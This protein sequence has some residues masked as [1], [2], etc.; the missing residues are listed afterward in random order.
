MT[1]PIFVKEE[2]VLFLK[3]EKTIVVG[4]LHIGLESKMAIEGVHFPNSSLRMAEKINKIC[5]ECHANSIIFLGDIKERIGFST[6][7]ETEMLR[8]F[9]RA[10]EGKKI[11]VAKGNHDA[12][13]KQLLESLN[14]DIK[15]ENEFLIGDFAIMHG[16]SWP[17][18]EA[19][20]K[21]YIVIGHMH[22]AIKAQGRFE[23]IW[24]IS[25]AAKK[26]KERYEKYFKGI[27]L[28]LAPAFTDLIVGSGINARTKSKL[29]LFKG[30]VFEFEN[31]SVYDL[32]GNLLGR[33]KQLYSD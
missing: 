6:Q 12:H 26:A 7:V 33:A 10:L 25:S 5:K 28:I 16:N 22:P 19:M 3:K 29:P 2:P 21:K 23:K 20:M 24:I 27:K 14:L 32:S 11:M 31:S 30:G 18:D 4:D 9:F 8:I 15:I 13:L 1:A 17:S